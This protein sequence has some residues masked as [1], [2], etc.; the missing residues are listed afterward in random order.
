MSEKRE[1]IIIAD[2]EQSKQLSELT[3]RL[4]DAGC[5]VTSELGFLSQIIVQC[6][7]AEIPKLEKLQGVAKVELS[8][9]IQLSPP[10]ND[11]Q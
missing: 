7:E 2:E 8:R 9:G 4:K 3:S 10:D 1:A 11:V 5:E 6:E